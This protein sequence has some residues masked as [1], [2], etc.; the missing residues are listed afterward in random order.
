MPT[1]IPSLGTQSR[2]PLSLFM[3]SIR[4]LSW[5]GLFMFGALCGR[6]Y[7][8]TVITFANG[9]PESVEKQLIASTTAQFLA[10][11]K[12][13]P[14]AANTYSITI[15]GLNPNYNPP[16]VITGADLL[17]QLDLDTQYLATVDSYTYV[18]GFADG[19][20]YQNNVDENV[21][22]NFAV[23]CSTPTAFQLLQTSTATFDRSTCQDVLSSVLDT[24]YE[25][26][27]STP[28]VLGGFQ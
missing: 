9:V 1:S 7:G 11:V 25:L 20:D 16:I 28:P 15:N 22:A 26:D 6:A 14:L 4:S 24:L 27:L 12:S 8:Y 2:K 21:A 5:T 23:N 18:Y 3:R 13:N 17:K 19:M 10:V